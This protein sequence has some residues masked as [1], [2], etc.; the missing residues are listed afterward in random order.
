MSMN[1]RQ[2]GNEIMHE[3]PGK[4]RFFGIDYTAEFVRWIPPFVHRDTVTYPGEI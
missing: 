3:D 2:R 1:F 4:P